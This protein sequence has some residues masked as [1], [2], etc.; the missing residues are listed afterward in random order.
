MHPKN[1]TRCRCF[2]RGSKLGESAL[3]ASKMFMKSKM[4]TAPPIVMPFSPTE[5]FINSG[6]SEISAIKSVG[7]GGYT[8]LMVLPLTMRTFSPLSF[9]LRKRAYSSWRDASLTHVMPFWEIT[10]RVGLLVPPQ[11]AITFPLISSMSFSHVAVAAVQWVAFLQTLL[12]MPPFAR[13]WNPSKIERYP[14]HLQK[15]KKLRPSEEGEN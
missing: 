15:L 13:V 3:F 5:C 14:V 12:L 8:P 10:R 9:A 4:G 1:L 11:Q 6:T 2:N 7:G